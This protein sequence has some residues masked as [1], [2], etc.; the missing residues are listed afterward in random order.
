MRCCLMEDTRL[1]TR[2]I[3]EEVE[4]HSWDLLPVDEICVLAFD[5]S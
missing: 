2:L 3:V 4:L 1:K 5:M